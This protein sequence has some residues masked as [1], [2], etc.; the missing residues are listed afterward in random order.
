M[1]VML[2]GLAAVLIL[3]GSSTALAAE[4]HREPPEA[5]LAKLL[6]GRTAGAP[7]DCINQHL[8]ASSQIIDKTAI[9]Y[10]M[11]GG[12]L[13]V[14][15]PNGAEALDRDAILV[16]KTIGDQLCRMDIVTLLDSGSHFMR[17]SVSVGA[18]IPYA[19]PRR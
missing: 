18:F 4:R 5:Q 15:R 6:E 9:V 11:P 3:A 12:A 17:G 14:N 8:I 10:R 16:S 1:R 7:V 2:Q 19:R 13:Y